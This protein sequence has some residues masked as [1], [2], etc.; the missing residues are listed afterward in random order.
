MGTEEAFAY[1]WESYVLR[2]APPL[3]ALARPHHEAWTGQAVTLDG[4]LSRGLAAPLERFEWSFED[5][6]TAEGPLAERTYDRPGQY[7]ETLKVIDQSGNFDYDF[8]IVQVVDPARP[9]ESTPAL[10]A[11]CHP[12][13]GV[14]PGQELT[15]AARAFS[16]E[17]GEELWDFGDGSPTV[18]TGSKPVYSWNHPRYQ[19][20]GSDWTALALDPQGYA[21]TTHAFAAPGDYLVTVRRTGVDGRSAAARLYVRVRN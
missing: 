14:L 20:P 4:S 15:F 3:M 9:E 19:Q 1:A 13:Q 10:H 2:Y 7:C 11:A 12:T 17:G 21:R 8:V 16:L 18:V 5:G 6:T